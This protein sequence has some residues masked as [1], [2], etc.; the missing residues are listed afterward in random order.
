[1][2]AKT[3][4]YI[5]ARELT[6]IATYALW[7]Y[8]SNTYLIPFESNS[9]DDT[10][11]EIESLFLLSKSIDIQMMVGLLAAGQGKLARTKATCLFEQSTLIFARAGKV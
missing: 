3:N 7:F 2:S 6:R 4:I 8:F 1:M 5:L 9:I 11:R 10:T